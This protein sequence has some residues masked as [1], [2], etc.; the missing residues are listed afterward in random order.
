MADG[1]VPYLLRHMRQVTGPNALPQSKVTA[2]GY[3]GYLLA[4]KRV[5]VTNLQEVLAGDDGSGH[6][7][8]VRFR[9]AQRITDDQIKDTD[10]CDIDAV[11]VRKEG[12]VAR[13][14]FSKY[15][16][17]IAD[18]TIEKYEKEA[19]TT[20]MVG[21]PAT[22]LMS[23]F[24]EDLVLAMNGIIGN[25]DK[26]L[27]A[28]QALTFGKNV[29]TGNANA[30]AVNIPQ[31]N[32]VND[33]NTGLT[34]MLNDA[35]LNEMTGALNIVGSGIF[36]AYQ[37]QQAFKTA[38]QNGV[39]TSRITGYNF[40][41][42]LYAGTGWGANQVGVFEQGAVQ[43]VDINRFVGFKAGPKPGASSFFTLPVPVEIAA[44][45][46]STLVLDCQLKYVDCPTLAMVGGVEQT[47]NR[48]YILMLSKPFDQWNIPTDAYAAADRL[49][50]NN[51]TLRYT[52]SNT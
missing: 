5:A 35:I 48:G 9:Y 34:K 1:F 16:M 7:V 12:A 10:N 4:Q 26:K 36:T 52:I 20:V 46:Y 24:Y 27:L 14:L 15:S 22:A 41:H 8:D 25:I 6:L 2:A 31:D 39:D 49:T 40:Y 32:T 11:P 23:E 29:V 45:V 43:L 18:E 37:L 13:T 21:K 47:V 50:G 30:V 51:G 19:S 33:L 17:Y 42:D 3:L 44:G 38:A 28:K